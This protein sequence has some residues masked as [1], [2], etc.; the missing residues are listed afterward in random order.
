MKFVCFGYLDT[1]EWGKLT[2]SQQ[3]ARIDAC[4]AYDDELRKGGHFASGEGLEGPDKT[5]SL[6]YQK[7]K[8]VVTDGPFSE[9]KEL[10][11][12]LLILEAR[13]L[14]HA[15]QLLSKHPGVTMGPWEIR[16]AADLTP[17]IQASERRRGVAK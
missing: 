3:T 8:V 12:G 7:G 15:V 16:A 14:D 11:G 1:E 13:D 6:R 17:M 5:K 10:L 2:E 4:L 9:T